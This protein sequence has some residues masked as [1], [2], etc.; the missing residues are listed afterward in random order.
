MATPHEPDRTMVEP[1]IPPGPPLPWPIGALLAPVYGAVVGLR[2]ARFNAGRGVVTLDRPV[3]SIGNLTVGGT[4]KTPMVAWVVDR[5]LEAGRRPCIAMRGY[6][7]RGGESDEAREYHRRFPGVPVVA[8]ADRV[9]GLIALFGTSEGEGV[10]CIVLD[11]GFQHRRLARQLDIVLIDATRGTLRDR[12]LPGG[13]LREPIASL[14]RAQFVVLTHAESVSAGDLARLRADVGHV[15]PGVPVAAARHEWEGLDVLDR[16]ADRPAGV[17]WLRGRAAV[18]VCGIG[19]PGP[20]LAQCR[21]AS[22]RD[23]A[24]RIVL[25]DHDAY[26]PGTVRRILD[27]ARTVP[28]SVIVT[29]GKDWAKLGRA[30]AEKWPCPVVRPRLSLR[31]DSEGPALADVILRTASQTPE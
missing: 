9:E 16:G 20:F 11:D 19:N 13:W 17:D 7:S 5:L 4:G 28:G 22:G 27:A 29:T 21:R 25:R 26:G 8:R 14:G 23:P 15:A 10:D 30:P 2:N 31:F 3:L 1:G 12:V 6:K 18:V 24:Y